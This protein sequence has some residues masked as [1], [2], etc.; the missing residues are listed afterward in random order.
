M[1]YLIQPDKQYACTDSNKETEWGTHMGGLYM[2]S[3]TQIS[4][5]WQALIP[6]PT[7]LFSQKPSTNPH[8]LCNTILHVEHKKTLHK[9]LFSAIAPLDV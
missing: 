8:L 7:A 5:F 6:H 9:H 2:H 1:S 3:H 4:T